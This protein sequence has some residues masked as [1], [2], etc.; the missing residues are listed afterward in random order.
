MIEDSTLGN[1][2]NAPLQTVAELAEDKAR[3]Q[4]M[5]DH[6]KPLFEEFKLVGRTFMVDTTTKRATEVKAPKQDQ[7]VFPQV[8]SLRGVAELVQRHG[9]PGNGAV[10]VGAN[11]IRAYLAITADEDDQRPELVCPYF[12]G[13]DAPNGEMGVEALYMWLDRF[14]GQLGQTEVDADQE[15]A[16]WTAVSSVK[17]VVADEYEVSSEGASIEIT[18]KTKQGV[19]GKSHLPKYITVRQRVGV[20]EFRT[21]RLYRLQAL[22][23]GKGRDSLGFRLIPIDTDGAHERF[24]AWAVDGLDQLL[25][26]SEAA[27]ARRGT[28]T[29]GTSWI[30]CEGP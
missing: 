5:R 11:G 16:I 23:P 4:A 12:H 2:L 6:E 22:L 15:R 3:A 24:V 1:I 8:G 14:C 10:V 19:S 7:F 21:E 17:A 28:S 29:P 27:I 30:V 9:H 26:Q 25:N 18:T 13:D 20:R